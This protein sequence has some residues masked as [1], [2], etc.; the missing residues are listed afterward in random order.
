VPLTPFDA[1]GELYVPAFSAHLRNQLA[2]GPGALPGP[3]VPASTSRCRKPGTASGS[4]SRS[5]CGRPGCRWSPA[6]A[7]EYGWTQASSFT[8][9]AG[10]RRGRDPVAAPVSDRHLAVGLVEHVKQVAAR[11]KLPLIVEQ[12]AQVKFSVDA[13]APLAEITGVD[14]AEG[15]ALR[16]GQPEAHQAGCPDELV[17]LQRAAIAEMRVRQYVSVGSTAFSSAVHSFAP[18]KATTFTRAQ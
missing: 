14:R 7:P 18:E 5:K 8:A 13:V 3:A 9:P 11:S 12:R 16:S 4:G 10:G 15:R 6:P 1:Q 2:A 17:V